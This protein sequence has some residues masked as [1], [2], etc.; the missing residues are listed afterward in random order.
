HIKADQNDIEDLAVLL[1]AAGVNFV[2]AAPMGD[3]CMLNYQSLSYHDVAT[4]RQ[5]LNKRPAP[6]FEDWL[7]KM[8]IYE[9]GKLSSIAGDPTIFTR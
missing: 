3:D 7:E 4:L 5:T 2:I 6:I 1:T 9:N 8:G